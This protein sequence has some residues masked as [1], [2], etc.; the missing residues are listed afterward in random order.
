MES[1]EIEK[2][3]RSHLKVVECRVGSDCPHWIRWKCSYPGP[4]TIDEKRSCV[5][6][7]Q[8]FGYRRR[9]LHREVE[10]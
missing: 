5:C 7:E 8:D 4:V 9:E 3:K 6:F 10:R 2:I 1:S